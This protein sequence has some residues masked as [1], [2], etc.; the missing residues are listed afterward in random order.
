MEQKL[1][2]DDQLEAV[3]SMIEFHDTVTQSKHTYSLQE[4][5]KKLQQRPNKFVQ[6][7]RDEGYI[8]RNN[9]P[10]QRYIAM[11]LFYMHTGVSGTGY[12]FS[13]ARMTTKGLV[14]FSDK[15]VGEIL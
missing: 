7:L 11:E 15:L 10:Y 6:W 13:Q 2:F 1:L 4:A 14:Y 12:E 3:K 8:M 5:G 9:V